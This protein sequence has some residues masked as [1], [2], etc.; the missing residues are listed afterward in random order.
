[1]IFNSLLFPPNI[2]PFIPLMLKIL[3]FDIFIPVVKYIYM[4]VKILKRKKIQDLS[5]ESNGFW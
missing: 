4:V 3:Q 2:L 5:Y 1:M